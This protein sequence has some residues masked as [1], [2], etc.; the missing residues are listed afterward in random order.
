MTA[1]ALHS[2]APW[3][4]ATEDGTP[5]YPLGPREVFDDAGQ[6]V[7]EV[8]EGRYAER[9]GHLIGAAPDLL[10][11]CERMRRE[12]RLAHGAKPCATSCEHM[13]CALMRSADA[14]IAKAR[15]GK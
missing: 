8:Y 3:E 12:L 6:A 4:V 1:P 14:A 15:G 2:P 9:N 10:A 7:C 11:A 13:R 5:M